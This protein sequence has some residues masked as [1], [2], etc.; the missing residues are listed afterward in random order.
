[1]HFQ[2]GNGIASWLHKGG[3]SFWEKTLLIQLTAT[4]VDIWEWEKKCQGNNG[5]SVKNYPPLCWEKCYIFF[6]L[7]LENSWPL[8]KPGGSKTMTEHSAQS[9]AE[10]QKHSYRESWRMQTHLE[11][12]VDRGR[13]TIDT[14]RVIHS[15][16]QPESPL[17]QGEVIWSQEVTRRRLDHHHHGKGYTKC[18]FCSW[19]LSNSFCLCDISY[20]DIT[21]PSKTH[22]LWK[23]TSK[24]AGVWVDNRCSVLHY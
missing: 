20:D 5:F 4:G 15:K 7:G 23:I 8:L 1:M 3:G 16:P 17:H 13:G 24:E 18:C 12:H 11:R 2:A 22:A 6:I 10:T 9:L 14:R 21:L 19:S